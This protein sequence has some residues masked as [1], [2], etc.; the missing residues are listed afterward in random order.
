M[1]LLALVYYSTILPTLLGIKPRF[2]HLY[3]RAVIPKLL[4]FKK[5]QNTFLRL[6]VTSQCLLHFTFVEYQNIF[7]YY[8]FIVI[9]RKYTCLAEQNKIR[10]NNRNVNLKMSEQINKHNIVIRASAN[11]RSSRAGLL[12][13]RVATPNG[14]A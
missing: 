7:N 11:R 4:T 13:L 5:K 3:N 2:F 1:V 12:K 8:F 9:I 14:V 10:T 6:L